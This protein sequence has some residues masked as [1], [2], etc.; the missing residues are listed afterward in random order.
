MRLLFCAFYAILII[1]RA[2]QSE[3]EESKCLQTKTRGGHTCQYWNKSKKQFCLHFY[4]LNYTVVQLMVLFKIHLTGQANH[5]LNH[6]QEQI[7]I[8]VP[9]LM[10]QNIGVIQQTNEYVGITVIVH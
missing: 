5:C 1:A 10:V 7:T 2:K 4:G 8:D 3:F 6:Y 9:K